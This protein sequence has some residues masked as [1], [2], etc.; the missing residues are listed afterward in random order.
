MDP[1]SKGSGKS[2]TRKCTD[3]LRD[4]EGLPECMAL[5]VTEGGLSLTKEV[6]VPPADHL[7]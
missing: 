7:P 3:A 6:A 2:E 4:S 5:G 1:A